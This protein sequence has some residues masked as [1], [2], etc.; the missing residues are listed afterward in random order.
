MA[1][2][3]SAAMRAGRANLLSSILGFS[4]LSQEVVH[5]GASDWQPEDATARTARATSASAF[6]WITTASLSC[7]EGAT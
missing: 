5:L 6:C 1:G 7:P 3:Q 2:D 4:S